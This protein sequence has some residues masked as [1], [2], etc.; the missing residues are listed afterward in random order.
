MRGPPEQGGLRGPHPPLRRAGAGGRGPGGSRPGGASSGPRE[1]LVRGP[2]PGKA[3]RPRKR[4]SQIR[5]SSP[6]GPNFA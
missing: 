2:A 4:T 5:R 1:Q 3:P 6:A